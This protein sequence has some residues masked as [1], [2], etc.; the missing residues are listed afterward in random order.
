MHKNSPKILWIYTK[1]TEI[2]LKLARKLGINVDENDSILTVVAKIED[3]IAEAIGDTRVLEPS[4]EQNKIAT[5]IGIDISQ[6][7]RRVAWAKIRQKL[8]WINYKANMAAIEALQLT[9]GDTFI[10][11]QTFTMP[12]GQIL[13]SEKRGVVIFIRWDG[14]VKLRDNNNHII[15]TWA[16]KL[17][18][19]TD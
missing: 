10:E 8:Q 1:P 7:S 5:E 14:S 19:P 13:E 16:Q 15:T 18:K 3:T 2:Q 6:D 12:N 9:V 17:S 4:S 11:R